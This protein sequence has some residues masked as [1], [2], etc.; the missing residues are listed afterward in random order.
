MARKKLTLEDLERKEI[1]KRQLEIEREI[2]IRMARESFWKY[3]QLMI[4]K[5]YTEDKLYLK[6][7]CENLQAFHEN[8]LFNDKGEMAEIL[9]VNIPPRH[10]KTLTVG[11]FESWVLGH[12]SEHKFIS[13]AYNA[14]LSSRFSKK[15]RDDIG[16]D[17]VDPR[18]FTPRDIFPELKLKEGDSSSTVWT[19]EGAYITHLSSSPGAA[20]TGFGASYGV[21][22]DIIKNDADAKNETIL[23]KHWEWF[24]DTFM[25]RIESGGKILLIMTRWSTD[26]LCG[27][28]LKSGLRGIYQIIYRA[29]D[30]K[31]DKM[32]CESVLSKDAYLQRQKVTSFEIVQANYQQDPRDLQDVLYPEFQTYTEIPDSHRTIIKAYVDTADEG[33]DYFCAIVYA[34]VVDTAYVLDIIYTQERLEKTEQYFK[35]SCLK[36]K[37]KVGYIEGNN[38]GETF[39]R[40][41]R[42]IMI[43][44]NNKLRDTITE[45][46]ENTDYSVEQRKEK[47]DQLETLFSKTFF[48]PF[49]QTKNKKARIHSNAF[50]VCKHVIMPTNW[51]QK[52]RDFAV[53]ILKFS[54]KG[55]N[56]HDDCADVITGV[57]EKMLVPV[58]RIRAI[59]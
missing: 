35:K 56:K 47:I 7:L 6:D 57:Y 46:S 50:N 27:R 37:V 58:V 54:R 12:D 52:F 45:I 3:C 30:E 40:N 16:S 36:K 21:I 9:I 8:K 4:P 34:E 55:K 49:K 20:I 25:S 15:I 33:S 13:C 41:M 48:E 28:I 11:L 51:K 22:D 44:H 38:G 1:L 43:A 24:G 59:N 10:G 42:N 26:D 23:E 2:A 53:D 17:S 19:V 39:A 5:F 32:L 31:Q 14:D 29:Y 18:H